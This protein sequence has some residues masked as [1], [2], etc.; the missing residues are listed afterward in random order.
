MA[1][2]QM[3]TVEAGAIMRL[4][5]MPEWALMM[6][7]H[8]RRLESAQRALETGNTDTALGQVARDQ[9][10]CEELRAFLALVGRA[11]QVLNGQTRS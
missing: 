10:R 8:Q 2:K 9:G 1:D 5:A 7:L 4:S 3:N 11:G 6:E